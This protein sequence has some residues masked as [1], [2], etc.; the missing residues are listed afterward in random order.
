MRRKFRLAKQFLI[1]EQDYAGDCIQGKRNYQ[2][3]D[4][5]FDNSKPFDFLMIL[6]DGM[7][8]HKGGAEASICAI[9]TFM[10]TYGL[11]T[12]T[13]AARLQQA[14]E[15]SNHQLALE[16]QKN[17]TLKGMGCTLAGVAFNGEQIQWISV[18]D[19]P[20]WLYSVGRLSRLNADHSMKPIL[21]KK[22]RSGELTPEEAATHPDRN[23]LRS[24]LTGADI[25]LID[26]SPAPLELYPGDRILLASDGIFTLSEAEIGSILDKSLPAKALV[27]QMLDAV[28][29]KNKPSQDNTTALIIEIPNELETVTK[30]TNSMRWQTG[31]LLLLLL[32]LIILWARVNF[33]GTESVIEPQK[34]A[35]TAITEI[36]VIIKNNNIKQESTE[37]PVDGEKQKQQTVEPRD[38]Q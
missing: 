13:V 15:Q 31:A 17:P 23:M 25:E 18:G 1:I 30:K 16:I 35:D 29:D 26:Q 21:Q 9:K 8:G 20:L 3:D 11:A 5:G 24:A 12:G 28:E 36:Q 14:L 22:V 4:F 27:K 19:S 10:D 38:K 37:L 33:W 6:A 2:E 7:G 34:Q 32:V